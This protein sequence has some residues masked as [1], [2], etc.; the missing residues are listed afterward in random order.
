MFENSVK[1]LRNITNDST[2]LTKTD[3]TKRV[4]SIKG[5]YQNVPTNNAFCPVFN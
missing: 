5:P 4:H 3:A 2:K 1:R